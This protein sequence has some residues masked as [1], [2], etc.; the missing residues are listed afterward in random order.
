LPNFVLMYLAIFFRSSTRN[1][2]R[3]SGARDQSPEPGFPNARSE[4]GR[5]SSICCTQQ[6]PTPFAEAVVLRGIIPN[7]GE[8]EARRGAEKEMNGRKGCTRCELVRMRFNHCCHSPS[9]LF[10]KEA[11]SKPSSDP[12]S[13]SI[14]SVSLRPYA[15]EPMPPLAARY[16]CP[17][18]YPLSDVRPAPRGS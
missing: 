2:S 5:H 3:P 15:D 11:P 7:R 12:S 13:A 16:P 9:S 10:L 8:V 18:V 6:G 14:A 1:P 4:T 17:P